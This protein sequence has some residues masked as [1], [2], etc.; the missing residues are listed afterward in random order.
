[1]KILSNNGGMTIQGCCSS[2][3]LLVGI[4]LLLVFASTVDCFHILPMSSFTTKKKALQTLP[5]FLSS[6]STSSSWEQPQE[7]QQN[8]QQKP[9]IQLQRKQPTLQQQHRR[10]Q[11]TLPTPNRGN[12]QR[13][14]RGFRGP[15]PPPSLSSKL[16]SILSQIHFKRLVKIRLIRRPN[17]LK[18]KQYCLGIFLA[19]T[20]WLHGFSSSFSGSSSCATLGSGGGSASHHYAT[21]M[22]AHAAAAAVPI[23]IRVTKAQ[24]VA[25]PQQQSSTTTASVARDRVA[26][27]DVNTDVSKTRILPAISKPDTSTII[28]AAGMLFGIPAVAYVAGRVINN[29]NDNKQEKEKDDNDDAL[30]QAKQKQREANARALLETRLGMEK[31]ARTQKQKQQ[32]EA[33]ARALLE[34]RLVMEKK[35]KQT[36]SMSSNKNKNDDDD[37]GKNDDTNNSS[38]NNKT[39]KGDFDVPF[40]LDFMKG[41]KE[42]PSG[43]AGSTALSF[44]TVLTPTINNPTITTTTITTTSTKDDT[45]TIT[46]VHNGGGGS[47][48]G[49]N[50]AGSDGILSFLPSS[51]M[52]TSAPT[53][54]NMFMSNDNYYYGPETMIF[55]TLSIATI[56]AVIMSNFQHI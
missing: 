6:D 42:P 39:G 17:L 15:P 13:R 12:I 9:K 44:S 7:P 14:P 47:S 27:T 38:N 28:A 41:K 19:V 31:K 45:N 22:V 16:L 21:T 20:M 52:H 23:S 11:S 24:I 33:N 5:S 8:Q 18:L 35:S 54:T 29:D 53:L 25:T 36:S 4:W 3:W 37:M 55:F 2:L 1:M 40:F 49:R 46:S 43:G 26:S 56:A 51:N 30:V 48:S 32:A 50:I 10:P 34:A